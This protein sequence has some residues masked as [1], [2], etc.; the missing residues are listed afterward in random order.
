MQWRDAL[1][2]SPGGRRGHSGAKC[3]QRSVR[4]GLDTLVWHEP[5]NVSFPCAVGIY[6][7][8][9]AEFRLCRFGFW[10][11]GTGGLNQVWIF[12]IGFGVASFVN[13]TAVWLIP[14]RQLHHS[15]RYYRSLGVELVRGPH[16]ARYNGWRP[17]HGLH[18]PITFTSQAVP[19][20]HHF[21]KRARPD[22]RG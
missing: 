7:K 4:A 1:S 18:C 5:Q 6:R 17:R 19:H 13:V 15:L 20:D 3:A 16:R 12:F 22:S 21:S 8:R 9:N 11:D 10:N 14:A 2:N